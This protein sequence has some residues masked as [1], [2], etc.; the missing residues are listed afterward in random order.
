MG[1]PKITKRSGTPPLVVNRAN[2][3]STAARKNIKKEAG[4]EGLF[5]LFLRS[6]IYN[7]AAPG[8]KATSPVQHRGTL[9]GGGGRYNSNNTETRTK[10]RG[11]PFLTDFPRFGR[12]ILSRQIPGDL[13]RE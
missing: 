1:V 7:A 3:S 12:N 10:N 9:L 6:F 4:V 2:A 11:K 5:F 8:S 13:N